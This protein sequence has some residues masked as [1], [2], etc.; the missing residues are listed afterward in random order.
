MESSSKPRVLVWFPS[1]EDP[2]FG[3]PSNCQKIMETRFHLIWLK[4]LLDNP[5]L[6][7]DIQAA[8]GS[9]CD[10]VTLTVE[11][12]PRWF[13]NL[14]VVVCVSTGFDH[15]NFK[16]YEELDIR[17][18]NCVSYSEAT[19]EHALLLILATARDFIKSKCKAAYLI[20]RPTF[21]EISSEEYNNENSQDL[22]LYHV[23]KPLSIY[24]PSSS[25]RLL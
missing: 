22:S 5:K 16:K 4:D 25:L 7:L 9:Y 12:H 6:G 8:F 17:L 15:M 10:A 18:Y 20:Y 2:H 3:I 24:D 23:F 21:A 11:T 13:P 1:S 14:K 19:A